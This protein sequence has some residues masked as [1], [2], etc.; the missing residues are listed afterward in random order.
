MLWIYK[1]CWRTLSEEG[2]WELPPKFKVDSF[3]VMAAFNMTE[4]L[5]CAALVRW[6]FLWSIPETEVDLELNDAEVRFSILKRATWLS[7]S[8]AL[9]SW[10]APMLLYWYCV[11]IICS[12]SSQPKGE[13]EKE[14]VAM[15]SISKDAYCIFKY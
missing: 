12:S 2:L 1:W 3:V 6:L 10:K 9:W 11:I 14:I 15:S 8:L 13:R 4:V 5:W 7:F